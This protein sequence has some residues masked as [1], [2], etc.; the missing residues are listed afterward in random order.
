MILTN[1]YIAPQ[2]YSYNVLQLHHIAYDFYIYITLNR[3][4]NTLDVDI[5]LF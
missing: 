1:F 5:S 3:I 4:F 2:C